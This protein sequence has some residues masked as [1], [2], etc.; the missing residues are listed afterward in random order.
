MNLESQCQS[1]GCSNCIKP[2]D[3]LRGLMLCGKCRQKRALAENNANKP[4]SAIGLRFSRLVVIADA[5]NSSTNRR[6]VVCV[7]D[8]G[9]EKTVLLG[10]LRKG[11]T[12][13]CGCIRNERTSASNAL[14]IEHGH[15]T[16]IKE[17]GKRFISRTYKSWRSMNERCN[18]PSAPNYHLYGGRGI[19]VVPEWIGPGGFQVFLAYIGERPEATTLDRINVNGN[20]EPGNVRW[21]SAKMQAENRRPGSHK[22]EEFKKKVGAISKA[23]W[24]DPAYREK[25]MESRRRSKLERQK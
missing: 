17:G 15:A 11:Q 16:G 18:S 6:R 25:M 3:V 13:S 20:Y 8:C 5:E 10:S 7:C 4:A 14:R 24:Q 19:T 23:L 9:K 1:D 22:S 21:A 12:E 2:A